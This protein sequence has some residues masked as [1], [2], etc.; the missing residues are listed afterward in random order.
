MRFAGFVN[1]SR[2]SSRPSVHLA[3]R[4]KL[5]LPS[6]PCSPVVRRQRCMFDLCLH[7]ILR[8]LPLLAELRALRHM[9]PAVNQPRRHDLNLE[10]PQS[11]H[12][13]SC[14]CRLLLMAPRPHTA[15]ESVNDLV[16][17]H[18]ATRRA[19]PNT[20]GTISYPFQGVNLATVLMTMGATAHVHARRLLVGR[21]RSHQATEGPTPGLP[22]I[23]HDYL[24]VT[25]LPPP[26]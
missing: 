13:S 5:D 1:G 19:P 8:R 7:A 12:A 26:R 21:N 20:M 9:M 15:P 24:E 14:P 2:I 17:R 18:T 22:K 23:G 3:T 16:D 6:G 4:S 25:I 10:D 11:S